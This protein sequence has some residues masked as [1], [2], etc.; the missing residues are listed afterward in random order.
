VPVDP[1]IAVS[2][3][4]ISLTLI[5]SPGPDTFYVIANGMRHRALGAVVSALGIGTGTFFHAFMAAIGASTLISTSPLAFAIVQYV[6]AAYLLWMGINAIRSSIGAD[7]QQ[8]VISRFVERSLWGVYWSGMITNAM[9]PKMFTFYIAFLPQFVEATRGSAASQIL[10][11]SFLSNMVGTAYLICVGLAAGRV[12]GWLAGKSL[13][14]WLDGLAGA[15][16]IAI[17]IRLVAA[18]EQPQR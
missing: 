12:S 3:L 6:G 13:G 10:F 4:L 16:F 18:S 1:A 14:R 15:F 2:Y 5:L 11:L 8:P 17:A 9:N 7:N